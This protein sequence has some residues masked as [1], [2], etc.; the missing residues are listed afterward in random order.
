MVI[1]IPLYFQ[2]KTCIFVYYLPELL[3]LILNWG[4]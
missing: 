2:V 4:S 1:K 3:V